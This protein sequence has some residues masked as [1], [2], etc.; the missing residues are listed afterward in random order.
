MSSKGGKD[1]ELLFRDY[2][3]MVAKPLRGSN[4][5]WNPEKHDFNREFM[6]GSLAALA[7]MMSWSNVEIPDS[8]YPNL[9][10]GKGRWPSYS[11][12]RDTYLHFV[13]YGFKFPKHVG[14]YSLYGSA[15]AFADLHQNESR[16]VGD[17]YG[18]PDGR[19]PQKYLEAL[20]NGETTPL[21]FTVYVPDGY[22]AGGRIPHVEETAEPSR[23]FTAEFDQGKTKWPAV[24]SS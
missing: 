15:F 4:P 18:A 6:L 9:S 1:Q 19:A 20:K 8:H 23:I 12:V 16:F 17:L 22:G 11:L 2:F 24:L 21:S 14:L 7:M 10:W 13:I 3:S 5:L